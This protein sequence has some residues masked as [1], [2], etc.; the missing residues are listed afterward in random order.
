M[1]FG[2]RYTLADALPVPGEERRQ[3]QGEYKIGP[4]GTRDFLYQSPSSGSP[5]LCYTSYAPSAPAQQGN[6]ETTARF[7][8][9]PLRNPGNVELA[10][11]GARFSYPLCQLWATSGGSPQ[12]H[13]L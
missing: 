2:L 8:T 11:E 4:F 12:G 9:C 6:H 5:D 3:Q 13:P 7:S 10:V 1:I